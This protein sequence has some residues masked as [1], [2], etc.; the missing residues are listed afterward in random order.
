MNEVYLLVS[1]GPGVDTWRLNVLAAENLGDAIKESKTVPIEPC[2]PNR[3]VTFNGFVSATIYGP[4]MDGCSV[5]YLL[6]FFKKSQPVH[7]SP[8]QGDAHTKLIL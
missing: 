2:W 4:D 8:S 5:G 6:D 1:T 3:Y 7:Q